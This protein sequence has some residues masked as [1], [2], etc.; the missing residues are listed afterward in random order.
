MP[1]QFDDTRVQ[2]EEQVQSPAK[3]GRGTV[4]DGR[5]EITD[6]LGSGGMGAVYKAKQI[7]FDRFAAIKTLH[8]RFTTDVSAVKRFQREARIISG[9]THKN[10]L[11]VYSF[12]GY[13]GH[14][15]LAMEFVQ[16]ASLG[17]LLQEK[18]KMT[19]EQ[20]IPLLLQICDGM[21]HAHNHEV[22][23]RDLKPDN[24]MIVTS[25]LAGSIVKVVDFGLAKLMDGPD[26]QRL[27]R[28]GEVVGDPRYMS[29]EQCRG[30]TLDVRSDVYSFGCLMYEVLTG[31]WPFDAE[32]P[33]AILH[34]H[35]EEDPEPF[36]KRLG[37]PPAIEAITFTAMAKK[38]NDRYES[39]AA[40]AK[41]LQDYATNPNAK[42]A[43]PARRA[44]GKKPSKLGL[45]LLAVALGV[46]TMGGAAALFVNPAD[47]SVLP[48]KLQYQFASAPADKI[49]TG[50][51]LGE[52]YLARGALD[53]AAGYFTAASKLAE[54]SRDAEASIR[55]NAGLS[56]VFGRQNREAESNDA[57]ALV[58]ANALDLIKKGN[59]DRRI[60]DA[61]CSVLPQY[62]KF[63]PMDAARGGQEVSNA[64]IANKQFANARSVLEQIAPIG[65]G[66]MRATTLIQIGD[67]DLRMGDKTKAQQVFTEVI[68]MAESPPAKIAMLQ[69]IGSRAWASGNGELAGDYFKQALDLTPRSTGVPFVLLQLQLAD[70]Y[71][72]TQNLAGAKQVYADALSTARALP[73]GE[74]LVI[75]SLHGLGQ[76][77]YHQADQAAA[78]KTFR[79]EVAALESSPAADTR[80]VVDALFMVGDSLTMQKQFYKSAIEFQRALDLIDKSPQQSELQAMR[81]AVEKKFHLNDDT[82]DPARPKK[83]GK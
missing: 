79:E 21:E 24:V 23:H 36:A 55:S 52:Y 19:P 78:E 6:Y 64:Y 67:L 41:A 76:V 5:Y 35:I 29:P 34:K 60:C 43:A 74:P 56:Q 25:G 50:M 30:E 44:R 59:S 80:Q 73:N 81:P 11:A 17:R 47:W 27:T 42:V 28:T 4:L 12:G 54:S 32:D 33:V 10:I 9:L 53:E 45:A 18:G 15:Y 51:Q 57:S 1:G 14:V 65:N 61:V 72:S 62:G 46:A 58:I 75:R 68:T 38:A 2:H 39:F 48:A 3:L 22:L 66:A 8:S 71:A 69:M 37:L 77:E 20:A 70:C 31:R 26:G 49:K 63:S 7:D 83:P 40:V 13:E 16:G 82:F